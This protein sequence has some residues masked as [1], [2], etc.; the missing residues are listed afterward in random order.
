MWF[1]KYLNYYKELRNFIFYDY[2][3]RMY[4]VLK[5]ISFYN[6]ECKLNVLNL[7]ICC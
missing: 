1:E 2:C 6:D 7:F 3:I 4:C 5:Y